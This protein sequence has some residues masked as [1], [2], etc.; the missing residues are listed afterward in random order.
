MYKRYALSLS[1]LML[2]SAASA[3]EIK[4]VYEIG[5]EIYHEDYKSTLKSGRTFMK[6]KA[7]MYGINGTIGAIRGQHGLKLTGRYA[8]GKS[9]HTGSLS[10]VF[11]TLKGDG[12]DRRSFEIRGIYEY[13]M[14]FPDFDLVPSVGLGYRYLLNRLD[15]MP[16]G[17]ERKDGY[18]F[19]PLGLEATFRPSDKLRITPKF[20]YNY[21]IEGKQETYY[22]V[23]NAPSKKKQK[24]GNGFEISAAF[25]YTLENNSVV[26]IT[27][28]YR[29]WDIDHSETVR[30]PL[31]NAL[32]YDP[33]NKTDEF[34]IN[35]TY[36]F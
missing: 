27:P 1:V 10:G 7:T 9:D 16:L 6:E 21:L 31:S 17:D 2:A 34:G 18:I 29:Y 28:F 30:K 25:A 22:Q 15:Q 23:E 3:Q 36:A 24:S 5:A 14:P 4:P 32:I 11:G 26:R 8:Q 33:K 20:G 35:V 13:T 12:L 19:L